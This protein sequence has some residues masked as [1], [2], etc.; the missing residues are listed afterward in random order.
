MRAMISEVTRP[1]K[2]RST[3]LRAARTIDAPRDRRHTPLA[4]R[5]VF[6]LPRVVGN[7][8]VFFAAR[9][10]RRLP[11]ASRISVRE[12]R[13]RPGA[14]VSGELA[15]NRSGI[16]GDGRCFAVWSGPGVAAHLKPLGLDFVFGGAMSWQYDPDQH[17]DADTWLKFDE[18]ERIEAVKQYHRRAQVR[19]PNERLHAVTHVIVEN[20]VALGEAY[21]VQSVLFRLMEEG[22]DR[23][24]A[25]H[26]IGYVLAE[27]LFA[28][29]TKNS[30]PADLNSEYLEKLNRLTAASW[31]E[32]DK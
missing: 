4:S 13:P 29:L 10:D 14:A 1:W 7:Q 27:R 3:V 31:K 21:P 18:S 15:A 30:Q 28:G 25:I 2:Q 20:Q 5:Q 22:L 12:P 24:D 16:G 19:L 11:P 23:H 6:G 9:R 32:Q 17:V 8:F 26:A